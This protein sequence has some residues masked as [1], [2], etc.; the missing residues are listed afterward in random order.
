M[1]EV[2]YKDVAPDA[3]GSAVA[4]IT[5]KQPFINLDDLKLESITVPQAATLELDYWK[6]GDTFKAFPDAPTGQTWGIWSQSM[7]GADGTFAVPPVL[8]LTLPGLFKS[9]GVSFAFNRYGPDWCSDL[10][11]KWYRDATV[12]ADRDFY[13]DDWSFPC[14]EEVTNYNKLVITFRAMSKPYRYLKVAQVMYGIVR[15]FGMDELR[16]VN[17]YQ[18]ASISGEELEFDTA[19]IQISAKTSVPYMFQRKQPLTV[20]HNDT[21]QGVYYISESE[22]VAQSGYIIDA[23][24]LKGLL[25]EDTHRGGIYNAVPLHTLLADILTNCPHTIAADVPNTPLTGWLPMASR[26]DNLQ[27]VAMAAGLLITTAGSAKVNVFMP[28]V[29]VTSTFD[30][31]SGTFEGASI[32]T[33]ALVT[34]VEVTEHK[35]TAGADAVELYNGTVSGSYE[36]AF[37][38]PMHSLTITGGTIAQSGANYAIVTGSG[39]VVLSGKQYKHSTRIVTVAHPDVA[40]NDVRNVVAVTDA[41]LVSASN[42]AAVAQREYDY[43]QRRES[44]NASLVMDDAMTADMVEVSTEFDGI[45]QG[46]IASL[47]T[48]LARKRISEAVIIGV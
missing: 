22:R 28:R 43:Y 26:R 41:T 27:Q 29:S 7:A 39:T 2:I 10:N 38:E 37:S 19:Q 12:L 47:D 30:A 4:A 40:A 32:T 42:S 25:D 24:D 9:V 18:T 46:H 5:D 34:A 48:D 16:S 15:V 13:P 45:K 20:N 36:I 23:I 11:I 14:I 33:N 35:Y 21:L 8:T 44:V 17:L 31:D 1:V 6:L 3:A